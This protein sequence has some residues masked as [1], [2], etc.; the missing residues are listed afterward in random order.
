VQED[1]IELIFP[2]HIEKFVVQALHQAHPYEVPAYYIQTLENEN[3]EVGAG[4]VGELT[5]A[6]SGEEFLKFL[7]EKM[8]LQTIRHTTPLQK[9]IKK[10]AVCGGAGSF[11]LKNAISAGADAFVSADFKYHEFF[12]AENKLIIADIGH[13]ESEVFTKDWLGALLTKKFPTFA[14][15]FSGINTNPISYYH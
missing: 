1:R 7:K 6:L 2:H 4:M 3:H 9:P 13:Y 10:V 5:Q 8:N 11:L 15:N 14:V 12:D